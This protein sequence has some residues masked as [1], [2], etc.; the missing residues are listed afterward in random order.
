MALLSL[1]VM[2]GF[3]QEDPGGP[4]AAAG[5]GD[6]GGGPDVDA[7]DP[8]HGVARI[9][10]LN[11]EVSVR[12][13]DSGDVI[14]AAL[15]APLLAQDRLLTSSSSRAEV[16]FDNA[17]MARLGSNT[18]LRMSDLE[19][20][21]YIA[22]LATGTITYRVL[23]DSNANAE[24]DTPSVAVRPAGRGVYRITVREDGTSE[25]TVRSGRADIYSP[26]GSQPLQAP[27][28][29]QALQQQLQAGVV[30]PPQSAP[31]VASQPEAASQPN[32]KASSEEIHVHQVRSMI[33]RK[34]QA[35]A[36]NF[37]LSIPSRKA[38]IAAEAARPVS[39]QTTPMSSMPNDMAAQL[40]ALSSL[41]PN[42]SMASGMAPNAVNGDATLSPALNVGLD[43]LSE[44]GMQLGLKAE[45]QDPSQLGQHGAN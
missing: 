42:E 9:S 10:L 43:A 36:A 18:E 29:S 6:P 28:S 2:P 11:G 19:R 24:I 31:M 34:Q 32:G 23:R 3:A 45:Q 12:R 1:L 37:M 7:G 35:Q 44:A 25:I 21:K 41:P 40:P 26:R 27:A 17:N 16:Q 20:G 33:E 4:V 15:N 38:A 13:G 39:G 14:A 8:S 30:P 22:E 5:A